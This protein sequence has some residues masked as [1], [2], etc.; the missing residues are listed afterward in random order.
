MNVC[1]QRWG[2]S[3]CLW[4]GSDTAQS[5]L[6]HPE[7]RPFF[8]GFLR[9]LAH[10]PASQFSGQAELAGGDAGRKIRV[11]ATGSEGTLSPRKLTCRQM[12]NEMTE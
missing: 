9:R 4:W 7:H 6:C 3:K 1:W 8:K 2:G 12:E 10:K 5:S 11:A